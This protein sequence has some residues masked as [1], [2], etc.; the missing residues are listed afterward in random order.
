[1]EMYLSA[2]H[3]I[4]AFSNNWSHPWLHISFLVFGNAFII[5][6]MYQN[7]WIKVQIVPHIHFYKIQ[8]LQLFLLE[9]KLFGVY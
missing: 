5:V 3:I 2:A 8:T 1:M 7:Y 6:S 9:I 4:M